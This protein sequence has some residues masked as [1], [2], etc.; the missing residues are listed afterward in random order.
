MA[1]TSD[2]KKGVVIQD[3]QGL[4]VVNEFQHINPG[5]GAAFVRTRIKNLQTGKT[6]ETTYKTS[7]TITLVDVE[8][9]RM[10]Y[11]FND[12]TGYTFMDKDTYDQVSMSDADVGADGKYLRDGMDINVTTYEGQPI[13]LEL[14]RKMTFKV[15]EAMDASSG[16][17]VSGGNM[18][19]EVTVDGGIKV[20]VPL[21]IKQG[22]DIIINTENGEYVERA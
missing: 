8:H 19:K 3:P 20:H 9:R 4:W 11:L 1:S 21:F 14:P 5:K 10:Q 15:T 22:E 12:A 18:T 6:L 16:N 7:E 13:A 17:T 2:I